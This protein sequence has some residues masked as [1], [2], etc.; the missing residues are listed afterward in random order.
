MGF[1]KCHIRSERNF[2]AVINRFVILWGLISSICICISSI[3]SV[4]VFSPVSWHPAYYDMQISIVIYLV[5]WVLLATLQG[6]ALFWKFQDRRFAYKWVFTTSITGFMIMLL[7]DLIVLKVMGTDTRG[8]GVLILILSLPCLAV[9]GGLILGLAQFWVIRNRYKANLKSDNPN[10]LWLFIS[11]ISWV[12]GMSSILF[13]G[14]GVLMLIIFAGVGSA[15]KG[16]FINKYL[17]AC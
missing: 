12:I 9:L 1:V 15:M 17:R 3:V 5:Y 7:H 8:Q 6:A 14:F 10:I 2:K 13:G 16:W 4:I 11:V